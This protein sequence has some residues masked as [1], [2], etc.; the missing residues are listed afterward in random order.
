MHRKFKRGDQIRP[1]PGGT[2]WALRKAEGAAQHATI[3]KLHSDRDGIDSIHV[4]FDDGE[5]WAQVVADYFEAVAQ[6][7]DP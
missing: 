3:T 4:R 7:P 2:Y 5:E 6:H 1:I